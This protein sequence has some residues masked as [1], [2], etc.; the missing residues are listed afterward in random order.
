MHTNKYF[1][2]IDQ[3]LKYYYNLAQSQRQIRLMP[4]LKR[5]IQYFIQWVK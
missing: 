4:G 2:E 1:E 5:N 3:D